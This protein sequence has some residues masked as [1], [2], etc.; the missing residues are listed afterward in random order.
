MK[1]VLIIL[2]A[3]LLM[4]AIVWA[5]G[6]TKNDESQKVNDIKERNGS[7]YEH[8]YVDLGLPSG[9]L[10]A[11]CNVG[12]NSPEEYGSFFAWGETQ[13]KTTYGS[14]NYK[15]GDTYKLTKYCGK[16]EY[17]MNHYKD[18]Y[19]TLQASDDVATVNWGADWRMP[20]RKEWNE[21]L[22]NTYNTFTTQNGVYGWLFTGS[23]LETLFLPAAYHSKE[24]SYD[25]NRTR[26][27]WYWSS[28]LN[29]FNP[30][31]AWCLKFD[32]ASCSMNH[33]YR[34]VGLSVRAVR[35]TPQD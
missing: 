29:D 33:Y 24:Q 5:A 3:M 31:A 26:E 2:A 30:N 12:A 16:S 10:W 23:T 19:N 11:T 4:T 7:F 32:I 34:N 1:K 20:T 17:G 25:S 13:T 6:F 8:E 22:W 15:Y 28:S 9:T 18:N 35:S 14:W 27:G 21:L